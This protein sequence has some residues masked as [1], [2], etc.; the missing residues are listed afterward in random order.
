MH[1]EDVRDAV[2]WLRE[3]GGMGGKEWVVCGHSVGGTMALMLG[4]ELPTGE[5]GKWGRG[6]G[7]MEGLK[8]V[9]GLEGIYDFTACRDAHPSN[10]GLYDEFTAGAFGP[11]EEGGWERGNVVR[12]GRKVRGEVELVM[13]VHSRE[14]ELVEWEQAGAMMEVLRKEKRDDMVVFLEVEGKHQQIVT[15]G[16]VIGKV[17]I[18]AVNRLLEKASGSR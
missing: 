1:I 16:R 6:D 3:H 10:R 5:E 9:V 2:A 12:S 4:L 13:V 18:E 14:D 7:K 8:G 11:E 17:V 15:E